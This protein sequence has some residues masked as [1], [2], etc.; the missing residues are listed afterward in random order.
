[1]QR[2]F[3]VL[4][5]LSAL[6]FATAPGDLKYVG[7]QHPE[8]AQ[9]PRPHDSTSLDV[10]Q[11]RMAPPPPWDATAAELETKG[12]QLRGEKAPSDAL[13][14]YRAALEKTPKKDRAILYN[15]C[16]I[17]ELHLARYDEAERD[18]VNALKRNKKYAEAMNNL[19]VVYYL[20]QKYGKAQKAYKKAIDTAPTSAAFH[21]NLG[22]AY[23]A[24][25][26]YDLAGTEYS[27]AL[28][29]DPDIFT[30]ESPAGISARIPQE[31]GLLSYVLAKLLAN[32]GKI[33]ESLVYL[34]RAMDEGYKGVDKI[35]SEPDFA[36]LIKDPRFTAMMN[37][38]QQGQPQPPQ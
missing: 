14:Y 17:T 13:D 27:R 28:E 2:L 35:Y 24:D 9:K 33:E 1:M 6:A 22:R 32:H 16:G 25:K 12:D 7:T 19:G 31:K 30:R 38:R 18:F 3:A 20:Q 21:S 8:D 11:W 10:Q 15:K 34:R 26:K 23:F 37:A 36:K 29:I 4:A 5:L